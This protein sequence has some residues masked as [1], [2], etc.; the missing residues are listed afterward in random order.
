MIARW[1]GREFREFPATTSICL[2][3]LVVFGAMTFHQ[4]A[5]GE[6]LPPWRWLVPGFGGGDAFGDLTL[7]DLARGQ[8]WRLIT[9]NFIHYSMIHLGMN[10]MAMYQLGSVAEVWYGPYQTIFLFGLTGGAGNLLSAMARLWMRSGREVH[11]G[12]GSVAIM[13]LVGICAVVGW[14]SSNPEGRRLGRLMLIFIA[15]TAAL[16]AVFAHYIDNWGHGGGLVAGLAI[17]L[18]HRWLSGRVGKPSAWGS[19][20]LTILVIAGSAAAQVVAERR[21]APVRL[22]R[23]LVKRSTYL[24]RAAAELNW[25]RRPDPPRMALEKAS[26]WLDVLDELLD[27]R[28]RNEVAAL[29]PLVAAA[30]EHP[31]DAEARRA[32]DEHLARLLD[33]MRQTYADDRTQ[34]RRLRGQPHIQSTRGGRS[35]DRKALPRHR[36]AGQGGRG[37]VPG[38]SATVP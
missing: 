34:L 2:S 18:A 16:G 30:I 24:R 9:C 14:Q 17:G 6:P 29:R 19:G 20:V 33:R 7:D 13:G 22:E 4:I 26:K 27:R 10:L 1:L 25:L 35:D 12:G 11:S 37:V 5:M 23:M 28:G 38:P 32:I 3:W 15:L 36:A 8:V 21:D 31:P